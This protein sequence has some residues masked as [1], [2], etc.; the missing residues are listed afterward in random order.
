MRD[1]VK[2][3]LRMRPERI[4][5]AKFRGPEAFDLLQAM[6]NRSRRVRWATLHANSPREALSA[7]N[8]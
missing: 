1:M 6:N 2:N 5:S 7:L 3:C 8:P 4:S